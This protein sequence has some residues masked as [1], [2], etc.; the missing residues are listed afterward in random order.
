LK[1][2]WPKRKIESVISA[3]R[4]SATDDLVEIRLIGSMDERANFDEAFGSLPLYLKVLEVNCRGIKGC[5][6]AGVNPWISYFSKRS[7]LTALR[8]VECSSVIVPYFGML[9][10]FACGGSVESVM[11]PFR[12]DRCKKNFEVELETE[13]M[14]N[15]MAQIAIQRCPTCSNLA[16]FDDIIEEYFRFMLV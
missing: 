8:F 14:K 4:A 16:K 6:S 13:E 11:V 10:N 3:I 7:K 2:A 12:C 9:P 15:L 5:N 1:L